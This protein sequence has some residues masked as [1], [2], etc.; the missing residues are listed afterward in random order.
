MDPPHDAE[1][2][3]HPERL[4]ITPHPLRSHTLELITSPE[5]PHPGFHSKQLSESRHLLTHTP[6]NLFQYTGTTVLDFDGDNHNLP[7]EPE[8]PNWNYD[9]QYLDRDV[10]GKWRD[11][12]VDVLVVCLSLPFFA[13]AAA[14]IRVD[15]HAPEERQEEIFKQPIYVV[16]I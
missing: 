12:S 15:G 3:R 16:S 2:I 10:K 11:V 5:T 8:F 7:Y 9:P 6:K 13:L 14:V 1:S 4:T